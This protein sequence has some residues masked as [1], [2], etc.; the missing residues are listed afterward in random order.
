[1]SQ[2]NDKRMP[3][4]HRRGVGLAAATIVVVLLVV[5]GAMD[6]V[7]EENYAQQI[8]A[9]PSGDDIGISPGN[10][11][12][13]RRRPVSSGP[14]MR[15]LGPLVQQLLNESVRRW[16]DSKNTSAERG[17]LL[18][19]AQ[20]FSKHTYLATSGRTLPP[21]STISARSPFA[22]SVAAAAAS[23]PALGFLLQCLD[24]SP[25]WT[26]SAVYSTNIAQSFLQVALPS[27]LLLDV[28]PHS[29]CQ[30]HCS[31][32]VHGGVRVFA[33]SCC[34]SSAL[35]ASADDGDG[36]CRPEWVLLQRIFFAL[37][38]IC[39]FFCVLLI[40]LA[41][42]KRRRQQHDRSWALI[43]PF[44][45]GAITLYAIPLLGWPLHVP[46]SCWLA[47]F[48]RQLGFTLFYGSVLLK[49][50][51]NLQD[52]R[53]LLLLVTLFVYKYKQIPTFSWAIAWSAGSW[54]RDSLWTSEWPQCPVEEF[55]VIFTIIELLVLLIGIRFCYK[56]RNS[57]WTER[58]Q[59]TLAVVLEAVVSLVVN[60]IRL[61][62]NEVGSRDAQFL[63]AVLQLHLTISVNIA[64]IVTP[65]F[66]ISS[67]AHRRT[68][69][70]MTGMGSSGRA[71]PSLA[72]MRENLI[73]GT[74]DFQE[75]PIIDMNPE[76]IRAELKRV[77]TQLRMYK[78]KNAY[79]DNPHISKRK[80]GGAVKKA[81]AGD[82]ATGGGRLSS[83]AGIG[84][85]LRGSDRP[86]PLV[87]MDEDKSG[88]DLT[89]ESAP[90]NVHFLTTK[91]AG[92]SAAS[93]TPPVTAMGAD[94]SI[95]V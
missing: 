62:L 83:G 65:K 70:D 66:L 94:C 72:K 92:P 21:N 30:T 14:Q 41:V 36:W 52:Y 4:G 82:A 69:S 80:G 12:P 35:L 87:V 95:R 29:H 60:C 53:V 49:I 84:G 68:L 48:G 26:P 23:Q 47:M 20:L 77:Y 28:C 54:T 19:M 57:N 13:G 27:D 75:V 42:F 61:S 24:G 16:T 22:S 18:V 11:F 33:R 55:T 2:S 32:S 93:A 58:Y 78:L 39:I 86:P 91:L 10:N 3:P 59:F 67:E 88:G 64:A 15:E 38:V 89:V 90:H 5:A 1:M 71:H 73:N 43:E 81:A 40:G 56:A 9:K 51:R 63:L 37:S 79:Q 17:L 46:W 44:F 8:P 76:D 25:R 74:I 34:S 85:Q 6:E 7:D 50:Y 45:G 31:Y